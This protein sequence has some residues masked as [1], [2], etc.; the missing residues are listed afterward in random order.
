MMIHKKIV[1]SII[2]ITTSIFA[3]NVHFKRLSQF[4]Y[5]SAGVLPTYTQ[6]GIKYVILTRE[7]GGRDR[8]TYD[9][10]GGSR[11][12]GET[13]P[14]VTAAR[15]FS[16]EA[17]IPTTIHLSLS[18]TINYLNKSANHIIAYTTTE[19]TGAVTYIVNFNR[20]RKQ[21]IKNFYPA[22]TKA[23]SWH[24]YEKD[25]LA[26]VTWDDFKTA[27]ITQPDKNAVVTVCASV[28][29]PITGK[30][31]NEDITLRPFLIKRLRLFFLNAPYE[32]GFSKKIRFYKNQPVP[33]FDT[34]Y[35]SV[36]GFNL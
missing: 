19:Q 14:V 24:N 13:H 27:I 23:T 6:S 10:F 12:T 21:F 20:Y 18:A 29:D 35:I 2:L 15:E 31:T 36:P 4:N 7:R 25:M 32:Q 33:V 26:V 34:K 3:I 9:D 8:G 11:D 28:L 17:N 5:S 16:E 22:L 30:F 1:F